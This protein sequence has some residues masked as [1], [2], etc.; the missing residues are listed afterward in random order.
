MKKSLLFAFAILWSHPVLSQPLPD[1]P[2]SP[3][4]VEWK[5][6]FNGPWERWP[7]VP[8]GIAEPLALEK[9]EGFQVLGY[10]P[11]W[12]WG[13]TNLVLHLDQLD[14]IAYFGVA[15]LADGSLGDAHHWGTAGMSDLVADAHEA[16]VKVIITAVNFEPG[17]IHGVLSSP[18]IRAKAV[19]NLVDLVVDQGGDGVNVDFEGLPVEDKAA[20]VGF[21]ISLKQ[22]LDQALGDSHV[23]VATPA[24]DWVGAFDYDQ[25]A[26][27]SDGLMIMGYNY[28]WGT[29][30]PGP[31]SPLKGSDKWGKYALD[32]TIGDYVEWGGAA[33]RHKYILGLPFYGFDWPSTSDQAPGVAA[34]K[35]DSLTYA[36]CQNEAAEH[37]WKWDEDSATPWYAYQGDT[38]HQV[39]CENAQSFERKFELI[40]QEALGGVGLWALGYEADD[41][42]PWQALEKAF[43]PV[44]PVDPGPA[45]V[46]GPELSADVPG[47]PAGY[48]GSEIPSEVAN[49]DQSG[50]D[51]D[52]G[53]SGGSCRAWTGISGGGISVHLLVLS[54]LFL[55]FARRRSRLM[56]SFAGRTPPSDT[57]RV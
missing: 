53:V 51:T 45:E 16:G 26:E 22:A 15:V 35:G 23:S 9:A 48:D 19:N 2:V 43:Q 10:L 46:S 47:D 33:N 4:Q 29:G 5:A 34:G 24:V 52:T 14:V 55:I 20:F 54:T 28:H 30:D 17:S 56:P 12:K 40:G 3:M 49:P 8:Y 42:G 18:A 50:G 21:V 44:L 1:P 41:D 6:H 13:D 25:L 11:Y 31:V 37:G 38:W 32:W 36:Q 7:P 27:A 39:W 57:K